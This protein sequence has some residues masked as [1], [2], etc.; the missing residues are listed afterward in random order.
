MSD[1]SATRALS[2][3]FDRIL[4]DP[5]WGDVPLD[6][7]FEALFKSEAFQALDGVRQLG[8]VALVY[9][10]ATH[11]R[12]SHS[13]GV[14]A[15]SRKLAISLSERGQLA[16]ATEEGVRSF[17][18]AALCHD[19]G[20]FPYAHSLKELPLSPH[21]AL[22]AQ[23]VA[24]SLYPLVEAC[25]ADPEAVA[26]IMDRTQPIESRTELE[27][28]R[29]LLSGVLDPDKVDYLT[30]DA[31]FCGVP[32][33]IQDADYIIRRILVMNQE[34]AIDEKGAMSVEAVLFSKYQ[35]YRSV[36]WHP[37]VRAATAMVKKAVLGGADV[38]E[39]ELESLYGLG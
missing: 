24:S 36:Y 27:L 15:L 1:F 33:G 21:E 35:M 14:Y 20:H 39:L 4:R 3:G 32:Y 12:R 11:S 30:R 2:R 16:H 7:G 22:G 29:N 28:Y 13:L 6:R 9:P 8:P 18:A 26:S 5:V 31:F 23:M 17:L 10:G 19:L 34:P 38:G 25:G 37:E